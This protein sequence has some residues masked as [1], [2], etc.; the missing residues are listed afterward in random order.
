MAGVSF[1]RDRPHWNRFV[2]DLASEFRNS[3][4]VRLGRVIESFADRECTPENRA[5]FREACR[6]A[7]LA[8]C[9]E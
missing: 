9:E 1:L 4:G 6:R 7:V 8:E 2:G 3:V 5:E